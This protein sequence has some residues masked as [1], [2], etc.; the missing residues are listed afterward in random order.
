MNQGTMFGVPPPK[1]DKPLSAGR[2]RTIKAHEAIAGGV[3]PV[4]RKP[5][6]TT[7]ET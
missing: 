7:G 5:L 3:H 4:T 6:L 1:P 2:R